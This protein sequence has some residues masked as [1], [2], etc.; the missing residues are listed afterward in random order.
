MEKHGNTDR[1]T[2]DNVAG[3]LQASNK[4]VHI[5][6]LGLPGENAKPKSGLVRRKRGRPPAVVPSRRNLEIVLATQTKTYE[7]V[8][9]S[10]GLSKQR[11]SKIAQRWK[12]YLPV[13]TPPTRQLPPTDVVVA[14]AKRESRPHVISFRLTEAEMRP[15]R[16]R[17]AGMKSLNQVAREIL[18]KV[19]SI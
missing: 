7:E 10:H 13:P 5:E 8:G 14:T 1:P 15:L 9:A 17:C 2:G 4:S 6:I 3:D 19:L 18:L 16:S 12:A 11:V